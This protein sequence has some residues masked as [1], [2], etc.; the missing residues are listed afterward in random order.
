[1]LFYPYNFR[2]ETQLNMKKCCLTRIPLE[3]KP[4]YL[5]RRPL[6]SDGPWFV[7]I[8]VERK[9]SI[10]M[11]HCS[12]TCLADWKFTD[13]GIPVN[14]SWNLQKWNLISDAKQHVP[15]PT[16]VITN[17]NI[18]I[19]SMK[20]WPITPKII[21]LPLLLVIYFLYF[22]IWHHHII[23]ALYLWNSIFHYILILLPN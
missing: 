10:R 9:K 1:M 22:S 7:C 23:F 5:K 6:Y 4:L 16:P 21:I 13:K 2:K 17:Q 18:G 12:K 15:H 14:V 3:R 11:E 19:F 8:G 20:R